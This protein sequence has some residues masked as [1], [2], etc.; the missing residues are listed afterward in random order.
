MA[1]KETIIIELD[2]DTS[3]FTK[4]AAKLNKEIS[5]LNKQQRELKKSGDEG[6]IQF[7]K[8]SEALRANKKE[9]A[10]TN[11]TISN[12]TSANKT[13]AGSNEQL[14]AQLSLLTAEYNKLSKEER[15]SGTRGKELNAQINQTT[16]SLK[17]NEE[18]VGDNRRSVGDYGK[19]LAGTPFGSFIG[20]I[21]AMGAAFIANPIGIIIL[22][23]IGALKLLK[24]AFET[25]EDGQNKSAKGFAVLSTIADKFFDLIEPLANF[26]ADYVTKAFNDLG[27]AVNLAAQGIEKALDFLGFK[28]AA[29][30]LREY[31]AEVTRAIV[32]TQQ[33][34]DARAQADKDDR[35]LLVDRARLEGDIS[36]LKLKSRQEEEFTAEERKSALIEAQG[37]E[38]DLLK[39]EQAVAKVRFEAKVQEN[40]FAKTNK[41]NLQEEAEL[42]AAL[43][44]IT[45]KR[46]DAARSTQ[47]ELNRVNKEVEANNAKAAADAKRRV[48]EGIK[49]T[50]EELKLFITS[51][52]I[53]AKSL[54]DELKL[55]QQ[56]RDKELAILQKQ[57]DAKLITQTQ[58]ENQSLQIQQDFLLLQTEATISN[59]QRELDI[60]TENNQRK[61]DANQFLNDELFIQEQER[62]AKQLEADLEFQALRLEQGV[63]N[64]QEFNDA[65]NGVNAENAQANAD[66]ELEKKEADAEAKIIDLENQREIDILNREDEFELA[67]EDL[68]RNKEQELLL[69]ETTGADKALIEAKFA[70]FSEDLDKKQRK[71]QVGEALAAFDA[72]A[73]L[74]AG[75]AEAAKAIAIAQAVI[76]GFQGVT[77]VLAAVSTIPEPFGSIVK[78][79]T[80]AAVGAT[81]LVNVNK[82]RSTPVPKKKA[83]KG[84][85]FGGEPHSRGGTKGYF[86]DGTQIEVERGELFAVVNKNSTGMINHL[87]N[88]NE[89]GGGVPFGKG[90]TKTFLQDGGIGLNSVSGSIQSDIESQLQ[91]IEAIQSL[92]APVVI[93]QD[94]NEVQ[95]QTVAVEQRAI[96]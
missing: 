72:I 5:D 37:L 41:E 71:A 95:G 40:T 91:T 45:T 44:N 29:D 47:R 17:T 48:A 30:G 36:Q 39:R 93:V 88:I 32:G 27:N 89:M 85:I 18:G 61:I 22:A 77:A 87:S 54:E 3:D 65:I 81:A 53:R 58:F 6:S 15:E 49:Q 13:A 57:L 63:I 68:E 74:A 19:A 92:P 25:T 96:L 73:G 86:S 16:A 79:V 21:K 10:E 12:L 84:G 2:F 75:N 35:K 28:G 83:A 1:T 20:G 59:A 62:L 31:N 50:Q 76:N 66:L 46:N 56:V 38:D 55:A 24:T 67:R 26:I 9:L 11:K 4:D 94:I 8:N 78:G 33:V 34:A 7:Q 23:I 82:I 52:G 42:E 60:L 80:A 69:A 51:Q 70:K 64:Q 43:L 90:G 14:K